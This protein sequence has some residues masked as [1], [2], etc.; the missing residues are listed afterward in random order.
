MDNSYKNVLPFPAPS[1]KSPRP[2]MVV[3]IGDERFAIRWEIE[4]L[5]TEAPALAQRREPKRAPKKSEAIQ[6][7]TRR[8]A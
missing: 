3:Q 6:I 5:P 7:G 1:L 4:E 2:E 8:K